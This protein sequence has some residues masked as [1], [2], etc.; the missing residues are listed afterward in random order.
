MLSRAI[1]S[2]LIK[3]LLIR[4]E[5]VMFSHLQFADDKTLV[6]FRVSVFAHVQSG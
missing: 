6:Y 4:T 2:G 3:S 5:E 1:D